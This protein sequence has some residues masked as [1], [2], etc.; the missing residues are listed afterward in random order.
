MRQIT[1]GFKAHIQQGV[2]TVCTCITITRRDQASFG[3]TDHD[4][5]V[6]VSGRTY[7]PFNSFNRTS[8]STS[9]TLEVDQMEIDGILN[10][11]AFAREEI[12]SGLFDFAEVEVFLVNY[13][14]PTMGTMSLRKGWIGEI[15]MNEDNSFTAE[16][17]GLSQVL[18]YRIG[19]PYAPECAADLGDAR[20]KIGLNPTWWKPDYLYR[21]GDTV[22]GHIAIPSG[23]VNAATTNTNFESDGENNVVDSPTGWITY[24]DIDNGDWYCVGSISSHLP[25]PPTGGQMASIINVVGTNV[26]RSL[27]IYQDVDLL[28]SGLSV[29][30]IDTGTCRISLKG[31][32][33]LMTG[34]QKAQLRLWAIG[35]DDVVRSLWDTGLK[36]YAQNRWIT[37]GTD[38]TLIPPGTRQVRVDFY[39]EKAA[40]DTRGTAFGGCVMQFNDPSGN[41]NSAELSNAVMFQAQNAGNSGGTEP[42]FSDTPD[43]TVSDNGIVWKTISSFKTVTTV[44]TVTDFQTFQATLPH[45]DEYYDGGL[46]VWETGKNAGRPMQVKTWAG[47]TLTMLQRAFYEIGVGDR[48]VIHPG[49]DKRRATCIDK[50]ANILNFRGFPDV[51][52]QDAYMQTPNQPAQ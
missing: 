10:S 17:R 41:F 33:G 19:E 51:P 7:E 20:C 35:E 6:V 44:T 15:V 1:D 50:F 37:L 30:D 46:L 43:S 18:T 21:Q 11:D 16:L 31:W 22:L 2:T 4:E 32:V 49:C 26:C 52:G 47:G 45:G 48:F 12:G 40:T 14:D 3:L 28:A 13:E 23:F 25:A 38:T 34:D 5:P 24:G 29:E 8:I 42:A 36:A 9:S 39:G 27:G